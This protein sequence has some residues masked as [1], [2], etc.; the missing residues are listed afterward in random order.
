M[1]CQP[2]F[3]HVCPPRLYPAEAVNAD[4][5]NRSNNENLLNILQVV[6]DDQQRL[7]L[8][9][10]VARGLVK[11]GSQEA[12]GLLGIN[13]AEA[14]D[15]DGRSGDPVVQE[16]L[17]RYSIR[18]F[19]ADSFAVRSLGYRLEQRGEEL[20]AMELYREIL[21]ANPDRLDLRLL[22]A[23]S[24]SPFLDDAEQGDVRCDST[25]ELSTGLVKVLS[26][27]TAKRGVGTFIQ[28]HFLF[29]L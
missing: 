19:P 1:L 8:F 10:D 11:A 2:A 29:S 6:T 23:A 3:Y 21:E 18:V 26:S 12:A 9:K 28:V 17:L 13:L 20:R 14:M 16:A 4:P 15:S 7:H 27:S 22:L 5:S 24:C 25:Q